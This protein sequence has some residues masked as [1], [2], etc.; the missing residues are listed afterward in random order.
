MLGRGPL[1]VVRGANR[2]EHHAA[3]AQASAKVP[4]PAGADR[5]T[6]GAAA[7]K[8]RHA[9]LRAAPQTGSLEASLAA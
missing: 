5:R 2:L 7:V 1:V 3:L 6:A 9:P 8:R 4:P